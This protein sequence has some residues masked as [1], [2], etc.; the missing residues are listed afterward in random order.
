MAHDGAL[1]L[2]LAQP[3]A[4]PRELHTTYLRHGQYH[5]PYPQRDTRLR[6]HGAMFAP[7]LGAHRGRLPLAAAAVAARP[8]LPAL[9][10]PVVEVEDPSRRQAGCS[11]AV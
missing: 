7:P 2:P 6:Y 5:G 11:V 4:T 1:P 9:H 8:L 3:R 10:T